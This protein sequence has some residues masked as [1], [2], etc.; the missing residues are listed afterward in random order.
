[1]Q[2]ILIT[3][4]RGFAGRHLGAALSLRGFEVIASAADVRDADAV[5]REMRETHPDAVAHLAAITSVAGARERER[6]AWEVNAAGTLNVVLALQEHAPAARLLVASSAEVYGRIADDE[7][8]VGEDRP[9][10]PISPYALSK[11]ALE[12]ACTRERLDV[13]VVRPFPHTGP[14]QTETFA[15]PSFAGQIARIEAGRAKPVIKVGNLAAR[16]DY[17]DVR[18]VV[19]A[20]AALLERRGGPRVLNVSTG[21]A[22]SMASILDRLLALAGEEIAIEVDPSRLRQ[23]DLPL[24]V[25]SPRRLFEWTGWTP[26]RALDETLKDVLHAAR[27]GA[28]T[29]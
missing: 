14:G 7:G 10:A 26:T 19:D 28:S 15:I 17:T 9:V 2:R 29:Q 23:L 21:L 13:V 11:T 1:V 3:G 18:D 25:G 22:H 4:A 16:R 24:L 6:E 27:E 5:S 8:P 20:Y 12:V